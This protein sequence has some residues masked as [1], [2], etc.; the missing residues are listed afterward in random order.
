MLTSKD[1]NN[2]SKREGEY[3][4]HFNGTTKATA[5]NNQTSNPIVNE[6]KRAN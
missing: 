2:D 1:N 6:S 4:N 3:A 5:V